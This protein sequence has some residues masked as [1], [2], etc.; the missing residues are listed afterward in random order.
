M[1]RYYLLTVLGLTPVALFA[2]DWLSQ[3]PV[4]WGLTALATFVSLLAW[5]HHLCN[6]RSQ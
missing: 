2:G 3:H 6:V 5:H 1:R 4:A